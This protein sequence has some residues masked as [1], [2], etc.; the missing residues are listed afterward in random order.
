MQSL[1]ITGEDLEAQDNLGRTCLLQ[2]LTNV[3]TTKKMLELGANLEAR[4]IYGN[5]APHLVCQELGSSHNSPDLLQF[6]IDARGD[7]KWI[8]YGG[9]ILLHEA[10]R[11]REQGMSNVH[12]L[13]LLEVLL[14][15]RVPSKQM[16][17]SRETTLHISSL[18]YV[19]WQYL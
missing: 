5:S 3:E 4:E 15:L 11:V 13:P 14:K 17:Y 19:V 2:S 9:N 18:Q 1:V 7:P 10:S 16:N 8:N 6:L 12:Q